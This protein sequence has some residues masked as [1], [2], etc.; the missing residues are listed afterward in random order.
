MLPPDD[1][2]R[3]CVILV[4]RRIIF[5]RWFIGDFTLTPQ[6]FASLSVNC[7]DSQFHRLPTMKFASSLSVNC[8]DSQFH[9]LPSMKFASSLSVNCHDSQFWN[10]LGSKC[11]VT[12]KPS[13]ICHQR[14]LYLL[15]L[16]RMAQR[17]MRKCGVRLRAGRML[18]RARKAVSRRV[19]WRFRGGNRGGGGGGMGVGRWCWGW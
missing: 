18:E 12:Y 10:I 11:K 1:P 4:G 5:V 15:T 19:E 3:C 17:A 9:R 7:H 13:Y 2:G 6:Y 16:R 8:H 14:R